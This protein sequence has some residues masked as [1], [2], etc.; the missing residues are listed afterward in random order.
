MDPNQIKHIQKKLSHIQSIHPF[1]IVFYGSRERGDF[2]IQSD[3]NFF[4]IGDGKD[5]LRSSFIQEI[6][7][8]LKDSTEYEV[9]LISGDRTTF[10]Y[11][12]EIFEPTAVHLM[13]LGQPV[14]GHNL[15]NDLKE[16]WQ[17]IRNDSIDFDILQS[18]IEKRLRFFK[19]LEPRNEI[20]NLNRLEK[21][22][23]LTL[24]N[25]IIMIMED[26]SPIELAHM[27]IPPYLSKMTKEMYSAY[28]P[29]EVVNLAGIYDDFHL[30]KRCRY[31]FNSSFLDEQLTKFQQSLEEQD[32]YLGKIEKFV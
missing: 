4:L 29:E 8:I 22:L 17:E 16:R 12:M 24:Q 10:Q 32:E 31:Y 6:S 1:S 20:D 18:Y 14:F 27:D 26:L 21:M 2:N 9:D 7:S 3:I 15:F 19:R 13:E 28:L 30:L 11:R 5:Q 23:A 25:W